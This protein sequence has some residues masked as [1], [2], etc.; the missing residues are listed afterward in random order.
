MCDT[1]HGD[2]GLCTVNF[3]GYTIMQCLSMKFQEA[4][5]IRIAHLHYY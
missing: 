1:T 2:G 4:L 3:I 5:L